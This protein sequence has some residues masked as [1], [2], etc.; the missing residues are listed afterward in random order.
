M[1]RSLLLTL[2]SLAIL[3]QSSLSF[4]SG[5]G[6]GGYS[7]GGG[8]FNSGARQQARPVDQTYELGKAIY[9]GRAKGEPSLDYCLDVEGE[10]IPLKRKSVKTFKE[11]TY[12]EFA[13]NLYNCDEPDQLV[14]DSLTRDSLLYVVYYLNKRHKLNLRG[15]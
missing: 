11:S 6:G 4:A 12:N 9:T 14:A 13:N 2:A 3:S 1:Q 15:T 10:K 5:G 8:S 7:G